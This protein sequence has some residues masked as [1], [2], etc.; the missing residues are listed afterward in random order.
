MSAKIFSLPQNLEDVLSSLLADEK[1]KLSD[2]A[3]IASHV[4]RLSDHY[5]SKPQVTTPWDEPFTRIAYLAYYFPLNFL[6]AQAVFEEA[7]VRKFPAT[8]NK[9][10]EIIDFGSG[11]GSGSLPWMM[12]YPNKNYH[13]I[14]SSRLARDLHQ[15][16]LSQLGLEKNGK[17]SA[18]PQF[19]A[20][21][22]YANHVASV[23]SYSLTELQT[24]PNWALKNSELILIEPSTREDGRKLLQIRQEL[25]AETFSLWAPCVHQLSCP[26]LTQSKTDWCHDRI[27]LSPPSWLVAIEN[28]L[29]FKNRTL[30]FSYLLASR[31]EAPTLGKIRLVGDQMEEKGKTRQMVCR[32]D[33]REFLA[34][35]HRDGDIPKLYRGDLI[36]LPEG[37][38]PNPNPRNNELRVP[39]RG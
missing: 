2:S 11:L 22:D 30:T 26:L 15:K 16:I 32:G 8:T 23:F 33:Q 24:L 37:I 6:R 4:Q 5:I 27:H 35:L 7:Q 34:W 13:F 18:E 10:E 31:T 29:P 3:K 39:K 21:T 36:D 17:W 19:H 14:E 1:I 28:H 20:K 9:I 25:L 38:L 12:A